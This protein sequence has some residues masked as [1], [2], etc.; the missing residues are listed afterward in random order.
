MNNLE[1]IIFN[2]AFFSI[3]QFITKRFF[4]SE[5]SDKE[6]IFQTPIFIF[7]P[8]IGVI[9]ISFFIFFVN[10]IFP[11]EVI[12]DM[13]HF[14]GIVMI[15][16][17]IKNN[18]NSR[19]KFF[20]IF[21]FLIIPFILA[22]STYNIKFHY[23]AEA[24]HLATQAWILNSKITFGLSRFFIWHGHSSLYDY[25]QTILSFQGNFIYQ[26]YLNLIFFSLLINFIGYHAL[27]N[28]SELFFNA[29]LF[30]LFFGILDNFGIGG[31]SN[32]FIEIQMVGKPDVA[33][34][35]IY[36]IVSLFLIYNIYISPPNNLEFKFLLLFLTYLIQVRVISFSL[37]FL[38]IPY[39][40]KN[41]RSIK[42][43]LSSK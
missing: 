42:P 34:G 26:H 13:V 41:Y 22:F 31:G 8:L 18:L 30:I 19:I 7:Y 39:L 16:Y 21:S 9:F 28:R 1:F 17:F 3:G 12:K 33:V 20:H 38:F 35:V 25:L 2:L 27:F 40:L 10:F 24:Y 23:D 32:G 37:V 43:M 29:S 11:L 4:K 5:N 14:L 36:L 6:Y 15:L